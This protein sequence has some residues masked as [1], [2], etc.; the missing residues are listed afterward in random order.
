MCF[1]DDSEEID[2]EKIYKTI[3]ISKYITFIEFGDDNTPKGYQKKAQKKKR[4][5]KE[6]SIL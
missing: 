6:R 3:P 4:K 2:L 1:N 5:K